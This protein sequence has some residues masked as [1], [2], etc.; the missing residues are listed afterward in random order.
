MKNEKVLSK[1]SLFT[2]FAVLFMSLFILLGLFLVI[3]Y[4]KLDEHK[5]VVSDISKSSIPNIIK[6]SNIYSKAKELH[7]LL[8]KI[9]DSN[10]T[11]LRRI[12]HKEAIKNIVFIENSNIP[13]NKTYLNNI[14]K[15][16]HYILK[17][18][19][20]EKT[21]PKIKIKQMEF[22]TQNLINDFLNE[23]EYVSK[24][25]NQ[26]LINKVEQSSVE[27]ESRTEILFGFFIFCLVYLAGIVFYFKQK[28]INRLY[29]LNDFIY[30]KVEKK[31]QILED[32]EEDEI[33][34]IVK[35]FNFY[36]QRLEELS[37][38]DSLTGIANKRLFESK[39]K[40]ELARVQREKSISSCLM[41]D[42][43]NFKLYND[44][45]GHLAGD[46]CLKTV[47][48]TLKSIVKRDV[49]ILARY[50]G[51]EFICILPNTDEKAS[52]EI[53][54]L[55][56]NAVNNLKIPH[57][58]SKE[59]PYVTVSIG[60]KTFDEKDC[61]DSNKI[62]DKADKALYIAKNSG[63]NTFKHYDEWVKQ[64]A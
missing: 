56:V 57:E 60:I 38:M 44:N 50:G 28:I 41:I 25:N 64:F 39:F 2:R 5:N 21:E 11:T 58:H 26:V 37:L 52:K 55:L 24:K 17:L 53:A 6:I 36:S 33:S 54:N 30:N 8:D 48:K 43:D 51:E 1:N 47:A 20:R 12:S 46:D 63:K 31:G 62:M 7:F 23:I 4:I 32:N 34:F 35:S 19:E 22:H 9:I 45:Y 42:I 49:D 14:K 3:A 40:D 10:N 15:E 18:T 27:L 29:R 16:L 13:L 59:Y 61:K